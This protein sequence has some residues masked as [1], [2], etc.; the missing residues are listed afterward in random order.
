MTSLE[1]DGHGLVLS[2]QPHTALEFKIMATA[3]KSAYTILLFQFNRPVKKSMAFS[4]RIIKK[5]N[6]IVHLGGFWL[7]DW[8]TRTRENLNI[9]YIKSNN[10]RAE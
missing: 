8:I 7:A 2:R 1:K 3:A 9:K 10:Q 5:Q 6:L 4:D